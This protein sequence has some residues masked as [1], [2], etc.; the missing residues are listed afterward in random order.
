MM[1]DFIQLLAQSAL[2]ENEQ[3]IIKKRLLENRK[4]FAKILQLL[5]QWSKQ[6]NQTIDIGASLKKL[7]EDETREVRSFDSIAKVLS[8]EFPELLRFILEEYQVE[9]TQS[10]TLIGKEFILIKRIADVLFEAK[11][12]NG[13]KV[14]IHLEFERQYESDEQ[15][16]K[17]KLEYRHLMEMDD[18]LEG[19]TV[20]CNVFYLRGSPPYKEA[21]EERHVK[22]PTTDSRYSGEVKYKA[23]HL[24]LVTIDMV[25][26]RNLPF[27]LPFIVQ[28]ELQAET[29][30]TQLTH[31]ISSIRQQIDDH[32]EA[33]IS[34]IESLTANQLE[35]LRITIEYLWGRS[36]SKEVFNKSTLLM[37]MREQLDLRQNDIQRGKTE[38]EKVARA[39]M[40]AS[41]K[42][43]AKQMVHDGELTP[44]QM[45]KFLKRMERFNQSQERA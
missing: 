10:R 14:I 40:K 36:Y 45:E 15:M 41:M 32:E 43:V 25:I 29:S 7:E 26:E 21:I 37:L 28:S 19:K 13:N 6:T 17:R 44:E 2:S 35:T 11:D 31:Y 9:A 24:S 16:D 33:L 8:K 4:L 20:L 38:G 30:T 3:G 18:E 42:V 23:Y 5:L 34:M 1:I 12:K 39:S 27:L 22:L